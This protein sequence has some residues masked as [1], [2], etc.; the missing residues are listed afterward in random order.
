MH[1]HRPGRHEGRD[2]HGARGR[3]RAG[4]DADAGAPDGARGGRGAAG[5]HGP[6]ACRERG[7][8]AVGMAMPAIVDGTARSP[9][10]RHRCPTGRT[11]TRRA[12]WR[13][14]SGC[15][16]ASPST[17]TRP[18]RARRSSA[19]ARAPERGDDHRGHGH[20]RRRL[21]GRAVIR[22]AVGVAGAVGPRPLAGR[23]GQLS[24][25]AEI[26][27]IGSR[28]PGAG[29][30]AGPG[31]GLR[32]TRRRSSVPRAPGMP[33]RAPPSRRPRPSRGPS[34]AAPSTW[35]P[36]RSSCGP[37]AWAPGPTSPPPPVAWRGH[38]ANRSPWGGRGSSDH[39]SVPNRVSWAP[40][41]VRWP[42]QQGGH[43][44]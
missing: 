40:R 38:A 33:P 31:G 39:D 14:P 11:R 12:S 28:H 24:A 42:R 43:A 29:P 15:P 26:G 19:A 27:R 37:G 36:P 9:G 25:P 20:G 6:D 2:R 22:G 41:P 1:R 21:G 44:G 23:P 5:R 4:A 30:P 34:P 8:V 13:P 7:A 10:P 35:S 3:R 32:R 16:R 18:P 17:G